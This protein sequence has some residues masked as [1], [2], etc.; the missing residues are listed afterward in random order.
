M[1]WPLSK[2]SLLLFADFLTDLGDEPESIG[3]P[4]NHQH[5]QHVI[6]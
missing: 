1:Y 3:K 2:E 4:V 5:L 6:D